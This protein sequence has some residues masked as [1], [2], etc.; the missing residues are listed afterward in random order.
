MALERELLYTQN[1]YNVAG[2]CHKD[3]SKG[4]EKNGENVTEKV[5]QTRK[6]KEKKCI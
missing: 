2:G 6:D 5:K 1:I 3:T 4:L